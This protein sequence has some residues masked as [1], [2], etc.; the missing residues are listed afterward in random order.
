LGKNNTRVG[1]IGLWHLGCVTAACL[2]DLGYQVVGIDKDRDRI[3]QLNAGKVPIFEPGLDEMIE[4]N[5]VA[6][7]LSFTTD[8][9]AGLKA[10]RF[11]Y[12]AY[13]TPV[14]DNDEVDLS[15][16]IETSET[17]APWLE[18]GAIV[19]VSS[20][21][22]VGTCGKIKETIKRI[23]P[24]ADFDI[25]CVPENL[26]L[27]QAIE[28]FKHPDGIVI[29]ADNTATIDKV[30]SFFKIIKAPRVTMNLRSAEMT[31]HMLN[32]FLATSISFTNEMANLCDFLGADA[33]KV[34]EAM[35]LDKRIGEGLP[36][37]PGLGFAGGTLARDLKTLTRL[38]REYDHQGDIVKAV[39][40]VNTEQNGL[41]VKK[42]LKIYGSLSG[43][44]IGILGLTYKA[45]TS[46]LRRSAA[47]EIIADL[48]RE[49]AAIKA[50]DPK[51]STEEVK[52]H[53]EFLSC[54]DPYAAARN[55]DALVIIT[56]WPDFHNLDFDLIKSTMKN[57]LIIDTRNMLADRQLATKGISYYG[58]GR[59]K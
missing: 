48:E 54:A 51:A 47:L 11:V 38:W 19:L 58:V 18:K 6:D 53:T 12:I 3:R 55:A 14:D 26:R 2:A 37:K 1:V 56:D 35:R 30:E 20:Q 32:A 40:K 29:G 8:L 7:R 52:R 24:G 15:G 27:G 16:I 4:S 28:R 57:P 10:K 59:G 21:V 46:T 50:Y 42:L 13:D 49:G 45:G 5:M 31:K 23:N 9:K 44:I 43:R 34:A 36:L 25:A 17:M 33:L 22:P 39:L 41:V